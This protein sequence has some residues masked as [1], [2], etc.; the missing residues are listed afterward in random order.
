MSLVVRAESAA[1]VDK[2]PNYWLVQDEQITVKNRD[3]RS[4][5]PDEFIIY[6]CNQPHLA[7]QRLH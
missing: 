1:D 2:P 5:K 3:L 6:L 7:R 4:D